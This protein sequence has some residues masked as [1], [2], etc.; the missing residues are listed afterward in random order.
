MGQDGVLITDHG[1]VVAR[2]ER[3]EEPELVGLERLR[4]EGQ[5]IEAT[6]PGTVPDPIMAMPDG[7]TTE[8][9]LADV[10]GDR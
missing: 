10:R 7:L 6:E 9:L 5:V 1:R 2:L 8:G 3:Y 4:A